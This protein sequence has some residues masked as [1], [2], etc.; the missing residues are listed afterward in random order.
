MT[1]DTAA[2]AAAPSGEVNLLK[3]PVTGEM[4]SKRYAFIIQFNLFYKINNV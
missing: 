1:T 2:A 4:V 3:D